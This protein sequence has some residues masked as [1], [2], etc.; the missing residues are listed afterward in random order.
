MDKQLSLL[1]N[2]PDTGIVQAVNGC[3]RW[4]ATRGPMWN[5]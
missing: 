4:R 5:P 1:E 2:Y 3:C